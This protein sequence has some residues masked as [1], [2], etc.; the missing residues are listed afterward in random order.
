M[1]RSK[2]VEIV[3]RGCR[4]I[5]CCLASNPAR[6]VIGR[7]LILGSSIEYAWIVF[8]RETEILRI[9]CRIFSLI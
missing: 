5:N 1:W 4:A 9:M 6:T 2:K 7:T 8:D 3:S